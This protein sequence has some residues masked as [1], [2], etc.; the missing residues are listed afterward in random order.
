MTRSTVIIS[1][2]LAALCCTAQAAEGRPYAYSNVTSAHVTT[3]VRGTDSVEVTSLT[4]TT[5]QRSKVL[6]QFSSALSAES[7][8]GCP[9]SV[10]AMVAL[11]GET[12]RVVKRINVGSPDVAG[13]LHYQ[14]DRQPLDGTT[15][16]EV[17]AGTHTFRLLFR[18]VS[19][20]AR[21]LEVNY[22]N[23]QAFVLGE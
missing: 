15:V 20:A 4:L 21:Q 6:F 1:L 12:P 11:D 3:F 10:R 14:Y 17:E 5:T 9:C 8:D 19:G 18:Q 22:P 13:A 7:S 16:F 23:A 2:A